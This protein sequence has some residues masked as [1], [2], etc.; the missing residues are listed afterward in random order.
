MDESKRSFFH[1]RGP[2][3]GLWT[4]LLSAYLCLLTFLLST[5]CQPFSPDELWWSSVSANLPSGS[6]STKESLSYL[7]KQFTESFSSGSS[8]PTTIFT[9]VPF[10]S[11]SKP[12]KSCHCDLISVDCL[13]SIDCL[14]DTMDLSHHLVALGVH[15]RQVIKQTAIVDSRR[16][17]YSLSYLPIGKGA[18]YA[19]AVMWKAWTKEN[20]LPFRYEDTPGLFTNHTLHP[21]CVKNGLIG[22]NCF[23][24]P[25][26]ATEEYGE[27]EENALRKV[28][29]PVSE[30]LVRQEI[31]SD[32]YLYRDKVVK[33]Q[34]NSLPAVGH[35]L[36]FSHLLRM[37]FNRQP[38]AKE[39]CQKVKA[40][41]GISTDSLTSEQREGHANLRLR[42][43]LEAVKVS[44]HIRRADSCSNAQTGFE[45]KASQ[46]NSSAQPTNMRKCYALSVYMEALERARDALT[47]KYPGHPVEV[48]LSSDNSASILEEVERDHSLLFRSIRRWYMLDVDRSIFDYDGVVEG[49]THNKHVAIGQSAV[50]DLWL[51]SQGEV[52]I[53]HLG[54]RFGKVGWLLATA[55]YNRFVPFL[56]VDGHSFC[57]EI[58]EPCA[59]AKNH[60]FSME[61]C[62]TYMHEMS[63]LKINDDYWTVGSTTRLREFPVST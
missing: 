55:R 4:L 40:V 12:G 8:M 26:N 36:L 6:T 54:S 51:L 45:M 25:V 49:D 43:D 31:A 57:C 17:I 22:K 15:T 28:S 35:L 38:V 30:E 16:T 52:F 37:A 58:D 47:K 46:L 42:N 20:T 23:F 19:T 2:K 24:T 39:L 62:M 21:Y 63:H 11:P 34:G 61:N 32:L 1:L 9:K 59:K 10:L 3:T 50:A 27:M 41:E 53:G 44:V 33:G 5:K 56:S 14:P 13:D 48:Y 7:L 29:L 18:Q 60:I